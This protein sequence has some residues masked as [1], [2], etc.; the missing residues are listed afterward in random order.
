MMVTSLCIITLGYNI[1]AAFIW[2]RTLREFRL[3]LQELQKDVVALKHDVRSAMNE[4]GD[5]RLNILE[6]KSS[7]NESAKKAQHAIDKAMEKMEEKYRERDRAIR[8]RFDDITQYV[9]GV[10]EGLKEAFHALP[11]PDYQGNRK[12]GRPRKEE[13]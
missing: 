13:Q 1:A 8:R 7:C 12:R 4:S 2:T 10:E 5:N 11:T 9:Q 3:I 6:V